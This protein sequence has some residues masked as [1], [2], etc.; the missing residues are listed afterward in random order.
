M[1]KFFRRLARFLI[2]M[3]LLF[4]GL[5]LARVP[6][7]K[8]VG[9]FL[10]REDT[11]QKVEAAFIL[12]GSVIERSKEALKVYRLDSPLL[13]CM[14]ESISP[15]LEAFG[16]IRSD[17]ELMQDA[18]LRLGVDSLDIKV[19]KQG[20]STWEESEEILGYA[21]AKGYK[22]IMIISSKFHTRRIASVFKKKFREK[23]IEVVVRG[24]DPI[25]YDTDSWWQE[26]AGMIFVTNEY[27]KLLYYAWKY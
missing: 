20:T 6:I 11:S 21:F 9:N 22:R 15:D 5:Y 16:Y 1:K 3:I 13:I 19:L 8:A 18:L 24:A 25:K 17:A 4:G 26:E 7:L 10:I 23:E 14:G 2:V 27:L 12:S